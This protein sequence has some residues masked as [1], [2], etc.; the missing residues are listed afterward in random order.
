MM[1]TSQLMITILP[2]GQVDRRNAAVALGRK[3]KTLASW[4]SKGLGPRCFSIQGR[5]YYDWTEIQDYARGGEGG[6]RTMRLAPC[7]LG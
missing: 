1:P 5:C 7:D 6:A 4:K 2:G 3:P